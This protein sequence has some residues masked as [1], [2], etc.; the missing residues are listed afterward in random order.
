MKSVCFI[1]ELPTEGR[2]HYNFFYLSK[3]VVVCGHHAQKIMQYI[4][5]QRKL[6]KKQGVES[7]GKD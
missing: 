6:E 2:G 3:K 7:N 1:C 5:L 4:E